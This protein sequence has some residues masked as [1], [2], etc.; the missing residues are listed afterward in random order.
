M[1]IM[2]LLAKGFLFLALIMV[3][4]ESSI[5]VIV[6]IP[7]TSGKPGD[8]VKVPI[9]VDNAVGIAGVDIKLTYNS[10][11]I[12]AT[13]ATTTSLTT[14]FL[15]VKNLNTAGTVIISMAS[16]SGIVSGSGA[17]VDI[18]FQVNPTAIVG[19]S[20]L[21]TLESVS[22]SDENGKAILVTTQN[23]KFLVCM[24][25]ELNSDGIISSG[26]AVIAL[27]ISAQLIQATELQKCAG[28][29]NKDGVINSAD[30][31]L[32]LRK[33]AGLIASL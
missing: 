20:S 23:G 18:S 29:I 22:L 25:G 28:D 6:S 31:V 12:T 11:I 7:D 27:R 21:L 5:A 1:R 3:P 33:S 32:I 17:I 24:S 19:S 26:D 14:G 16:A 15:V 8:I 13:D 4:I 9:K 10:S 2:E 30:A